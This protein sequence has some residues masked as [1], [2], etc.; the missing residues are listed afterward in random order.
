MKGFP[1]GCWWEELFPGTPYALCARKASQ[2][3]TELKLRYPQFKEVIA[4]ELYPLHWVPL[5]NCLY[6]MV[7]GETAV[8]KPEHMLTRKVPL[9]FKPGILE[10]PEYAPYVRQM[11]S[12]NAKLYARSAELEA[13]IEER[14]AY[15]ALT[16]GNPL[17]KLFNIIG[18]GNNGKSAAWS[19]AQACM[20][21]DFV[22]VL[23]AAQ[24]VGRANPTAPNPHMRSAL[25]ANMT[26]IEEPAK[27][28]PVCA[29]QIKEMSGGTKQKVRNLFENGTECIENNT[30]MLFMSNFPLCA[31]GSDKAYINRMQR[32]EFPC[33]FYETA[34]QRDAALAQLDV[35]ERSLQAPRTHVADPT[36]GQRYTELK[37]REVYFAK[38][39]WHY[40]NYAQRGCL[41]E[42]PLEWAYAEEDEEAQ[43]EEPFSV[44]YEA[45]YEETGDP[46]DFVTAKEIAATLASRRRV[47]MN[48]VMIGRY[49]SGRVAKTAFASAKVIKVRTNKQRG[50]RGIRARQDDGP[51]SFG[52]MSGAGPSGS[53][54]GGDPP[55]FGGY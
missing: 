34:A 54:F 53:M 16:R 26:A 8:I 41:A 24:L 27:G 20:G 33:T 40:R 50:F 52:P 18:V 43:L 37:M 13:A 48:V 29:A 30:T 31:K 14:I 17:K 35:L 2:C 3:R 36:F 47:D 39:C 15:A 12:D 46:A 49:L 5:S 7:T 22:T 55:T 44:H 32:I 21:E 9:T 25:A 51:M 42:I 4:W 6:N 11:D 38:L 10:R 19:R 1:P 23:G 28:Q 45:L